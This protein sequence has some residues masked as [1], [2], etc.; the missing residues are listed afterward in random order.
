MRKKTFLRLE[1]FSFSLSSSPRFHTRIEAQFF[2]PN[3][4]TL[5][6]PR[7][8]VPRTNGLLA[9]YFFLAHGRH[10][11][12]HITLMSPLLVLLSVWAQ[13]SKTNDGLSCARQIPIFR[14]PLPPP[15][16]RTEH[17]IQLTTYNIYT[18]YNLRSVINLKT[19][20]QLSA[21]AISLSLLGIHHVIFTPI[22]AKV[23]HG[24]FIA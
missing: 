14:H 21:F 24:T 5:E 20:V 2:F 1:F 10:G 4:I 6:I 15:A 12:N 16:R 18:T 22:I 3:L 23:L 9:Y 7:P 8:L 11:T 19:Y 13:S 17:I